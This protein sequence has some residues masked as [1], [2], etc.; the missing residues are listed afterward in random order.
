MDTHFVMMEERFRQR[1]NH[2]YIKGAICVII[3][4]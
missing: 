3:L 1:D 2:L 4:T